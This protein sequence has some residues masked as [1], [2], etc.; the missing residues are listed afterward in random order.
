[1]AAGAQSLCQQ[2]H[3]N[4]GDSHRHCMQKLAAEQSFLCKPCETLHVCICALVIDWQHVHAYQQP[5]H[6]RYRTQGILTSSNVCILLQ[7]DQVWPACLSIA[8]AKRCV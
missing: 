6:E 3:T 4:A 5:L 7:L 8:F 1:M 2:K